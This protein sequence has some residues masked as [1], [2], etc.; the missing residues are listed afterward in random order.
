MKDP[1][2]V[3][4]TYRA[5]PRCEFEYAGQGRITCTS[6][7]GNQ[8]MI[9]FEPPFGGMS[10]YDHAEFK[11]SG[12]FEGPTNLEGRLFGELASDP[13]ILRGRVNSSPIP[14][15]T[16]DYT[17]APKFKILAATEGTTFKPRKLKTD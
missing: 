4:G 11:L 16:Y 10:N 7:P 14:L 2:S 3:D 9:H 13:I 5:L 8:L 6:S 15:K 12:P 1:A 17:F